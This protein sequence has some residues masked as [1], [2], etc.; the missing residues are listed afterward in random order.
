MWRKVFWL[1]GGLGAAVCGVIAMSGAW[2]WDFGERAILLS[3]VA[4]YV[5]VTFSLWNDMT[6]KQLWRIEEKLDEI[7]S[8]LDDI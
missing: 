1:P 6:T 5:I 7:E 2:Y 8:K 4:V 3:G